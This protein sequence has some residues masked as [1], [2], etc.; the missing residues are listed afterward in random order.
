MLPLQNQDLLKPTISFCK[1]V[2]H[3]END[4]YEVNFVY[5]LTVNGNRKMQAAPLIQRTP[6]TD[7]QRQTLPQVCLLFSPFAHIWSLHQAQEKSVS[8]TIRMARLQSPGSPWAR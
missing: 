5:N 1:C 7:F 4:Q 6:M 3:T 8:K 2:N